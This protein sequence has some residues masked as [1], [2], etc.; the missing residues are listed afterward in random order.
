MS[1]S[2]TIDLS[3]TIREEQ[4]KVWAAEI[5]KINPEVPSMVAET[6]V[7][8]Y[9]EDKEGFERDLKKLDAE[10]EHP[11]NL[12]PSGGTELHTMQIYKQGT[13]EWEELMRTKFASDTGSSNDGSGAP[14]DTG[15]QQQ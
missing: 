14:T 5:T 12:Q 9:L 13:P 1:N 7:R 10:K 15:D 11:F 2:E 3:K 8:Y 4:L 6:V